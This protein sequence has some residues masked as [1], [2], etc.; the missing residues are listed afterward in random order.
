MPQ[1]PITLLAKLDAAQEP[2]LRQLLERVNG[3][4]AQNAVLPFDEFQDVLHFARI[5]ILEGPNHP[6]EYESSLVLMANI[7]ISDTKFL[8]QLIDRAGAGVD[9]IFSSCEAYPSEAERTNASRLSFLKDHRVPTQAYYVNTIG[10]TVKQIL[11]EDALRKAIEDFLQTIDPR[12]F[13]SAKALRGRIV[14]YVMSRDVLAWA[15][16]PRAAL[17]MWWQLKEKIRFALLV[18]LGVVLVL[19]L[20][21]VLLG[22]FV[23][24]QLKERKDIPDTH[25][26]LLSR[27]N[28]LRAQEDFAAHNQFTATGFVK[29]G[30]LRRV[31]VRS[32]LLVANIA[33]RHVFNRGDLAG[34]PLLGLDGV[35]TI[36]FARWVMID[37]DKRLLF[38]SNYDG[39]LESY[40]VDFVDKVAWGLNLVFSNGQ[41]YP[42][43]NLLVLDGAR[44]EERFKDYIGNHQFE[45]QVWHT[46]YA[47]LTAVNIANNERIRAGLYGQMTESQAQAWLNL[48]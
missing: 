48:L 1:N 28:Q 18:F 7:D 10:R 34:V 11:Q 2:A 37:D 42:K 40:M 4:T 5:F 43:T 23:A 22:A 16:E 46:P 13:T 15:K 14:E 17:P 33:L 6:R 31:T 47:H 20:W 38:A 30:I 45:T 27:L 12:E 26:P 29:P 8:T 39:S 19:W 32:V 35:D 36:H 24:I 41:G 25:R 44:D 3:D 21:P 9:A